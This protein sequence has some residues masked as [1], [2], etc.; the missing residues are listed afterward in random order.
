MSNGHHHLKLMTSAGA[1]LGHRSQ[2]QR[3]GSTKRGGQARTHY[4]SPVFSLFFT[5]GTSAPSISGFARSRRLS[6]AQ[7]GQRQQ[8]EEEE[9]A[10]RKECLVHRGGRGGVLDQGLDELLCRGVDRAE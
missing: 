6:A 7:P 5:G 2:M 3:G 1:N 4:C 10:K 8:R 9:R